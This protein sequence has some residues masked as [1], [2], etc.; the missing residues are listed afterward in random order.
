MKKAAATGPRKLTPEET[1]IA[2]ATLSQVAAD[3]YHIGDAAGLDA[4]ARQT[5]QNATIHEVT[6]P[7]QRW[8]YAERSKKMVDAIA[9][10]GTLYAFP[11][12]PCPSGCKPSAPFS[13][14]GSGTWGTI[15]YAKRQGV[16]IE[17]FPLADIPLPDWL[18]EPKQLSLF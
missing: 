13:G 16:N 14:H 4:I 8:A 17:V 7:G 5:W 12:K 18:Q 1:A 2:L 15:A 11:N 3:E 6:H 10:Q 9:P